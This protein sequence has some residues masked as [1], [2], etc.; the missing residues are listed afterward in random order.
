MTTINGKRLHIA[1]FDDKGIATVLLDGER[2]GDVKR[3]QRWDWNGRM[4]TKGYIVTFAKHT[5]LKGFRMDLELEHF[6]KAPNR[7]QRR[8]AQTMHANM[9]GTVRNVLLE[10]YGTDAERAPYQRQA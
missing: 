7:H 8:I 4:R 10:K 3:L 5:G 6:R 2:Y 1:A 9:K